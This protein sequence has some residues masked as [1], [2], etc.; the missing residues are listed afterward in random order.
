MNRPSHLPPRNIAGRSRLVRSSALVVLA[1]LGVGC[2]S[3]GSSTTE[4]VDSVDPA[5]TSATSAPTEVVTTAITIT[6]STTTST[7]TTT[8]LPDDVV[9]IA[10]ACE[11]LGTQGYETRKAALAELPAGY[12]EAGGAGEAAVAVEAECPKR[13]NRLR[14]ARAIEERVASID[15]ENDPKITITDF[16]CDQ[17]AT[18]VVDNGLDFPIGVHVGLSIT[19]EGE[20]DVSGTSLEPIVVWSIE[21]GQSEPV[22]ADFVAFEGR[23]WNCDL[24]VEPFDATVSDADASLGEPTHPELTG[25]DPALWFPELIAL[26]NAAAS[27]G[28][29]DRAS[30]TEDL[31]SA[32]YP[33]VLEGITA[34]PDPNAVDAT[35]TVCDQGRSQLDADHVSFV[36]AQSLPERTVEGENGPE[37]A[38][39]E[40]NLFHGI[41]RR[42][43]DGQWRWLSTAKYFD[44]VTYS[45]CRD[46]AE[47]A[48]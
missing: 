10:A 37:V 2:S 36:S 1:A 6:T 38:P 9:A 42:G 4:P 33:G 35:Y 24:S 13:L 12:E 17:P 47:P 23:G 25:D 5:A 44:S 34:E 14:E 30:V 27:S 31:R 46:T 45:G 21:P 20:E 18:F 29:L 16:N 28:D 15:T 8:T 32:S 19:P 40:T 11:T 7:T 41:F 43:S 48:G 39:A 26:E 3:G 22:R